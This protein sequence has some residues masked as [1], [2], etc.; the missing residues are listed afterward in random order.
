MTPAVHAIIKHLPEFID[1][2]TEKQ[3]IIQRKLPPNQKLP[4]NRKIFL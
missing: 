3:D 2:Q 4:P 1:N